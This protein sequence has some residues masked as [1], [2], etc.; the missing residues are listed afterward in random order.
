M[1]K[2]V[3]GKQIRLV[4]GDLTDLDVDAIVNAANA[5]LVLGAGVAGAI[6]TRGGPSIQEECDR[7]GGTTVGQAVITGA[8][9][10]KARHV[11]HAVGP[12]MGEGDEDGKLRGATLNS[13][14]RA[15]ENKLSSIAFPAVSTGIF[16]FPKERCARIML[17]TVRDFLEREETTLREVLFCLWSQEDFDV[18]AR[19]LDEL[20]P[21]G[22]GG[23]AEQ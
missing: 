2:S 7:I 22:S 12:R 18:F 11:I 5:R 1:E 6:R 14:K 16:G 19:A 8:G 15:D 13:L 21:N 17:S 9:K 23:G 4:R 10:L 3:G 20:L